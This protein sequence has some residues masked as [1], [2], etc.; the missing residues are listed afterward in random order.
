MLKVAGKIRDDG[1]RIGRNIAVARTDAGLTQRQVADRLKVGQE[2]I[3][4]WEHGK[5]NLGIRQLLRLA[6][7]LG[8]DP[9]WIIS[10]GTAEMDTLEEALRT[11][12]GTIDALVAEIEKLSPERRREL[13]REL[14]IRGLV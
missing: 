3:S 2:L 13:L 4:R 12:R 7:V 10:N 8:T 5:I 6:R 11:E 9:G 1:Q 14:V